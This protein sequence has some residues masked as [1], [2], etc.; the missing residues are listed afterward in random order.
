MSAIISYCGRYRYQL[1]RAVAD[2]DG[3][4]IAFFGVNPSTADANQDDATIRKMLGFARGR[5]SADRILVANVFAYRATNVRELATVDDPVGPYNG[6]HVDEVIARATILVPC[7]GR[8]GK[9]PKTLRAQFD[10]M[11]ERLHA[12]RKPVY[13]F[14][15]TACGSPLHPLMLP[16]R[17]SL[18]EWPR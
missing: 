1:E 11:H 10:R 3:F 4:T 8:T 5:L 14:G 2:G 6:K 18:V 7:W 9:V 15:L 12:S 13:V 16:Y 17:T